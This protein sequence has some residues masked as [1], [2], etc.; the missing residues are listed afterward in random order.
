MQT[1]CC[2]IYW[3]KNL[4]VLAL[5]VCAVIF[6]IGL[7][8]GMPIMEIFMIAVALAVSAIPEG[9]PAIVTIVLA[10]GVQRMAK[11]NAIIRKA[12]RRGD[13]GQRLGDLFGQNRHPYPEQ[14]DPG[15]GYN[16]DRAVM[17]AIQAGNS[18]PIKQ[19]LKY[20][21]LCSDGWSSSRAG[22]KS[23]SATL[24]RPRLYWQPTKTA[25]PKSSLTAAT[26]VWRYCLS[27]PSAS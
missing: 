24:P 25:C 1:P 10:I 4:G 2:T 3:S 23:I 6:A 26:R 18:A 22:R 20:A 13:P 16:A 12:V 19:L 7:W 14:D 5:V 11:R 9:L 17:E 21:A 27:I 8:D 15:H